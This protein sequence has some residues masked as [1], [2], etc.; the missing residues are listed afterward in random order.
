MNL[1]PDILAAY[2]RLMQAAA[3][4]DVTGRTLFS[5]TGADRAAFL[6]NFCTADIKGLP[7][8]QG[9]EAFITSHQGKTLGHIFIFNLGDSLLIE[10]VL[11][12]A[13]TL[14]SHLER[15]VISE[16]VTFADVSAE[17]GELFVGGP[18]A[19]GLIARLFDRDV[20]K[21]VPAVVSAR[22]G[23]DHVLIKRRPYATAWSYFLQTSR[24]AIPTLLAALQGEGAALCGPETLEIARVEAG[25]PEFGRD[26]TPDNLPQEIG[27]DRE[28]ISFTKGCYLGQETV[29]RIDALGHVNRRLIGV[30]LLTDEVPASGAAIHV[31]EKEVGRVTSAVWSPK[32]SRPLAIAMLRTNH[33]IPRTP[34]VVAGQPGEVIALPA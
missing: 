19:G 4:S 31:G 5:V 34:L 30:K 21:T 28:A 22:L 26:I 11:G 15:F 3:A 33:V 1:T 27:R 16:D 8:D 29:A 24:N 32:L 2:E 25:F 20:P 17:Y 14:T 9:R 6:H 13:A 12:Q 23:E 10:T 7:A 18:L